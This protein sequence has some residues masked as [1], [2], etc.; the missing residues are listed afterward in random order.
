MKHRYFVACAALCAGLAGPLAAG[1]AGPAATP[2]GAEPET[3]YVVKPG[4]T[5]MGISKTLLVDGERHGAYQR[6]ARHNALKDPNNIAPGTTLRIPLAWLRREAATARVIAVVGDVQAG[7]RPL[8]VGDMVAE[9]AELASGAGGYAT[10][11]FADRSV[12][13]IRPLSRVLV[14]THKSA[15]TLAEFE[16]RLRLGAGAVEATVAKQ[17]APNF[18]ITTPTANMAVRGTEFRVRGSESVSQAEVIEGR[19][20]VASAAG[21]QVAVDAGFGT[22]VR[23]GEAPAAPVRLL[24]APDISRVEQLQQRPMVR[25]TFTRLEGAVT[26]RAVVATDRDM[27]DV[28]AEATVYRADVRVVDLRD[29]EYFYSLRGV[30]SLGLEG[31]EAQG[32]FRLKAHP[33]PP[34]SVAPLGNAPLSPG[35]VEFTWG[36]GE[37]AATF[38]FQLASDEGFRTILLERSG[39]AERRVIAE[40]LEPGRYYWRAASIRADGEQGPFGDAETFVVQAPAPAQ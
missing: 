34:T 16:T 1:A 14:E 17:R 24:G 40:R 30:D 31:R 29:G 2:A 39:L 36:N 5:L 25:L 37:E 13:R 28:I 18:R 11:E 20:G 4:D 3:T 32:R 12:L 21:A 27:R 38:R 7:G 8:K 22:V 10:L 15:P 9:G 19:V 26:Y 33:L 35:A 6:L 23:Q